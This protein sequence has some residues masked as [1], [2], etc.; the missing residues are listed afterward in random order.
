MSWSAA[1]VTC[2]TAGSSATPILT[3]CTTC[4]RTHDL[5]EAKAHDLAE[6]LLLLHVAVVVVDGVRVLDGIP[7]LH[8]AAVEAQVPRPPH[9]HANAFCRGA[10][11]GQLPA[12]RWH[13]SPR[14]SCTVDSWPA[15]GSMQSGDGY[16]K[17]SQFALRTD[18]ALR[19]RGERAVCEAPT[20]P[21]DASDVL[22]C[23][24]SVSIYREEI[25]HG[26]GIP[27]SC[28]QSDSI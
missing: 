16:I 8:H 25:E 9:R 1:I 22:H 14:I 15:C 10:H 7:G 12:C 2:S 13:V 21:A 4:E 5:R 3:R 6:Q 19:R 28:T 11:H 26:H 24:A 23:Q 27:M 17:L 18:V 20:L